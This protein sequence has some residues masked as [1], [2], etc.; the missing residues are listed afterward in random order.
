MQAV[1]SVTDDAPSIRFAIT[2]RL[3]RQDHHV[4]GYESGVALLEGPQD[5]IPDLVLLDVRMPGPVWSR[6][7]KACA[8][9]DSCHYSHHADCIWDG[10]GCGGDNKVGGIRLHDQV[11]GSVGY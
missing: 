8:S 3:T 1:I 5:N 7:V 11:G 10:A 9:A 4:V 2:K 6:C